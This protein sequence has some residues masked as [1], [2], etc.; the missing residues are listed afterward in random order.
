[1]THVYDNKFKVLFKN[2]KGTELKPWLESNKDSL[3]NQ[4]IF[5]ILK[6][7]LEKG[8][9][10]KIGIS[11]RGD[12][13]AYGRL[14]DYYH[15]YD[16]ST[17]SNPC[18]GV[19]LYL[20]LANTFNADVDASFARVRR[21]ETK[22]KAHFESK[23]ARGAERLKVTIDE[24][25]EYVTGESVSVEE[26]ELG[27][28]RTPRLAEKNQGAQDAVKSIKS[29]TVNRQGDIKFTVEF[30]ESFKYDI[31]QNA[32]K[33]QMP[34]KELTYQQLIAMRHGKRIADAYI[35]KHSIT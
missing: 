20:I 9:V 19:K 21:L 16:K 29:H 14:N 22:V 4:R 3:R 30:M 12:T 2:K 34:D 24:L 10:F 33:V 31:N 27:A 18:K 13:S 15:F 17:K 25:M 7:N 8:D 26:T 6:A 23:R 32:K 35:K 28:R 5:Y 1:M 11:E